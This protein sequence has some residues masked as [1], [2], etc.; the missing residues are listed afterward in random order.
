MVSYKDDELCRILQETYNKEKYKKIMMVCSSGGHFKYAQNL[1]PF[2]EEYENVSWVTFRTAI[3]EAQI[4]K[5]KQRAYWAYSPTNRNLPNLFRNILL[6]FKVL[7]QEKPDLIISTGAG[8]GVPFLLIGNWFYKTK[9]VF[10]ESKTRFNK[11]SLSAHLLRF[12]SALDKLIVRSEELAI[13]YP[14]TDYVGTN[15]PIGQILYKA[16]LLSMEQLVLTVKEQEKNPNK[17]FGEF[18]VQKGWIKP[19]TVN[20]FVEQLPKL[21]THQHQQPLGQYLKAAALLNDAQIK[22]ILAEQN[23][24]ARRFGEIAVLK[25][26]LKPETIDLFLEYFPFNHNQKKHFNHNQK[27]HCQ[28]LMIQKNLESK[29]AA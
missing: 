8:V 21:V 6:A 1:Q 22:T 23:K 3:T 25:G 10:A 2:L 13:R 29:L 12:M 24:V 27:N 18:L 5:E 4:Q 7:K 28:P 9:T 14:E 19:E 20:F 15:I 16:G 11:L 17:R 26:W